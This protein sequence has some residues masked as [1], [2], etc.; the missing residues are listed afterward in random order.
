M[1]P[2]AIRFP[3]RRARDVELD[4]Q[5]LG[6]GARAC[7]LSH[8]HPLAGG[9]MDH[10]V[11]VGLWRAAAAAGLRSLRYNFRGVGASTG[12]LT[13]R[14]PLATDDLAGAIDFLGGGPLLAIGYSYGARTTLHAILAGAPIERAVLVA[15]P[16]RLPANRTA[17]TNLLLGRRIREE[18][19]RDTPD[20]DLVGTAKTPLLVIAGAQD[21]LVERGE[22]EAR[23]V[24]AEILPGLNHF[25]SRRL[26][27]QPAADADLA[28]L[29]AR[30]VSFL[31][32]N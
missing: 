5:L 9:D 21:P 23:G 32:G 13:H 6:S 28:D 1:E 18:E 16:T 11:V 2:H 3:A 14:S 15:L 12:A 4:G 19:Y 20:L 31:L 26:G 22:L 17:M 24:P 7:V 25:F 30:A 8:P 29:G 27:N 10:P